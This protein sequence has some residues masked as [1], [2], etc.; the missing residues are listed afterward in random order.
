MPVNDQQSPGEA[1]LGVSP[2]GVDVRSAGDGAPGRRLDGE[3][4]RHCDYA[5][6]GLVEGASC[7]ECGR[8]QEA[9][10]CLCIRC[11][12]EITGMNAAQRCAVCK[13]PVDLSI[14]ELRLWQTT[15]GYLRSVRRGVRM[16]LGAM[17]VI[18]GGAVLLIVGT[19]VAGA[20][21]WTNS[22]F[23]GWGIIA[24]VVGSLVLWLLG[25]WR[26]TTPDPT[27]VALGV[28]KVLRRGVRALVWPLA[29][30]PL[31]FMLGFALADL[32]AEPTRTEVMRWIE[33][34]SGRV[35]CVILIVQL[36]LVLRYTRWLATRVP[37]LELIRKCRRNAWLLPLLA[38]A[39]FFN[40]LL[41][42]AAV[43]MFY[44]ALLKMH[45]SLGD[46]TWHQRARIPGPT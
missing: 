11:G 2:R 27:E 34:S 10:L 21:Q 14:R 7:P 16:I 30:I 26:L 39:G 29:G 37:N 15:P 4:C 18:V 9:P 17:I 24:T 42:L 19:V 32:L 5:L 6:D 45:Q 44:A 20:A 40:S 25:C 3:T 43:I 12:R 22:D 35:W 13:T 23:V 28:T 41:G 33:V 36:A 8:R 1:D 38:I 46:V 31:L